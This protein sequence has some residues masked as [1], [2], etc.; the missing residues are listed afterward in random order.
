MEGRDMVNK[1]NKDVISTLNDFIAVQQHRARRGGPNFQTS[2]DRINNL[3]D[4][5]DRNNH[6]V[7]NIFDGANGNGVGIGEK[8]DT[9]RPPQ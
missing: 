6:E 4:R 9:K 1:L 3:I 7:H 2:I 5:V 8:P